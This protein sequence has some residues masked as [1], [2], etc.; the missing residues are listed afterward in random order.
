MIQKSKKTRAP[1][2]LPMPDLSAVHKPAIRKVRVILI[3]QE[4]KLRSFIH[5]TNPPLVEKQRPASGR[6]LSF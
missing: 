5:D 1:E 3:G 4:I 2:L 6:A